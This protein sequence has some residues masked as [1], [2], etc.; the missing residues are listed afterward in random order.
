MGRNF[1]SIAS[2]PNEFT[3]LKSPDMN[4]FVLENNGALL[5]KVY[6]F[7]QHQES[8]LL[9]TGFFGT[10]KTQ[11]TNHLLSYIDRGVYSLKFNCSNS[12]KLDDI[13]L[14]IW[15]QLILIAPDNEL[16]AHTVAYSFQEKINSF[17]S[18]T[19]SNIVI[20]LY[21]F[22][23][24]SQEN[25]IEI[26][27]FLALI[28]KNINLKIIITAKT[29]DTTLLPE[30]ILYSKVILK[31][32]NRAIFEK[33]LK[34]NNLKAT[35][36][37]I[38]ELYKITRGYY[39]YTDI[40]IKILKQK[41]LSVSDYLVAYTNSAM[42]FDKFLAKAFISMLPL[43]VRRNLLLLSL[44][45]HPANS[46]MLDC[47]ESY[48]KYAIDYLR[49]NKFVKLVGDEIIINNYFAKG[50]SE[51][52]DEDDIIKY[53]KALFAFYGEQLALKPSERAVL[54]SRNTMRTELSF[55]N[56]SVFSTRDEKIETTD[57][58]DQGDILES[59]FSIEEL[60]SKAKDFKLAYK[61]SDAVKIYLSLLERQDEFENPSL[62]CEIYEELANLYDILANWK[63]SLHY[64]ELLLTRYKEAL[65]SE[66]VEFVKLK[67]AKVYY[68][69]YKTNEAINLLY[70]IISESTNYKVT[71]ASYTTLGNIYISLAAKDKAYELYSKAISLSEREAGCDNLS[72]LYF[73]FSILSDE[74]GETDIAIR[75]Y[76]KCIS[77]SLDDDKYK[78]LSYSNLGDLY[79]D[80]NKIEKALEMFKSAYMSDESN[81]NDYGMYY[82]ASNIS[83]LLVN[84]DASMALEYMIKAQRS[85]IKSKDLF[86]I[87]NSSL[88]LGD[89]Y[90]NNDN[91]E[92]GIREYFEVLKLVNEKFSEDNKKK[93]FARLDDAK[94]RVG[95]ER[96][97][98]LVKMYE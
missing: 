54:I 78:S 41:D 49:L 37:I 16:R 25:S 92:Y 13:L 82:A 34:S 45:R 68:Q 43:E 83:K 62:L 10:G 20:T 30:N 4:E 18:E 85:A 86:A 65:N 1:L 80:F 71:I 12:T 81:K 24:I 90:C 64:F 6:G 57:N 23:Q 50:I 76:E 88:H 95:I 5:R 69:S 15:A 48:D 22:D 97:T 40:S 52:F 28:S 70:E 61:Y 72:E 46:K 93:I 66:K 17:F 87:A 33:Y 60:L 14:N 56:D 91:V 73:K 89:Y 32:F 36:R 75:Y 39:F 53:H 47:I 3:T 35:S 42:S 29:F 38:D 94:C 11:I 74:K 31:A 63:Y 96:Y 55:H 26:I 58:P 21:D 2:N 19:S 77:V 67:I 8:I 9:V 59:N 7:F 98:E 27:D 44:I 84:T 79:L 51:E